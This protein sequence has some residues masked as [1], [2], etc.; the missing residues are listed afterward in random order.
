MMM[1]QE[2]EKFLTQLYE[3]NNYSETDLKKRLHTIKQEI[4]ATGSYTH[5]AFELEKGA[6]MAWRNNN[7]CIGRL[8]WNTLHVIDAREASTLDEITTYLFDH[9]K[10]A[11]N[12][13]RIKPYITIFKPD[14]VKIWNHQLIRYAGYETSNGQIGDPDSNEFTKLCSKLGWQGAKGAFDILPLLIQLDQ[15]TS[16]KLVNIPEDII[17]EV[18]ITHP[19][20][21]AFNQLGLKWYAVP[22][23]SDMVLEIGG[24][25]YQAAPF[26]GWYMETEIGARDFADENR[27]NLLPQMAE[28]MGLDQK[29]NDTLWKDK[30]LVE[31]NVAVLHSF[32]QAKVQIVDHHTAA[33]QFDKFETKELAAG[34]EITGNWAWL[35]PPVSPATTTIFHRRFD[36]T[37]KKPNF[38]YRK[39]GE[40][41]LKCPFIH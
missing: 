30:A 26:N 14:T 36:N 19:T 8:F 18:P 35:I 29:R 3:E 33:K 21:T 15:T 39:K 2:A 17:K 12:H 37:I 13:G 40:K 7:H 25:T 23:I 16:P 31:L 28:I 32:H 22:I 34:R 27:Y 6:K 5:T 10:K 9:I 41:V 1:Y 4:E 11:T 38:F 24:I 20:Y